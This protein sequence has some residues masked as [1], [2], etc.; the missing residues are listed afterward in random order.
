MVV[1]VF[2]LLEVVHSL[3]LSTC[4]A[5]TQL[6]LIIIKSVVFII[7]VYACVFKNVNKLDS[8]TRV[9]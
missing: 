5:F 3:S 1:A 6:I 9:H 4:C 7:F 2:S 8:G